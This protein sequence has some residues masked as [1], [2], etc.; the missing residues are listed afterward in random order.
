[1]G[2]H[3]SVSRWTG[4]VVGSG[5]CLTLW[6]QRERLPR[7]GVARRKRTSDVHGLTWEAYVSC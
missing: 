1:V 4:D 3:G 5:I 7:T 2:T 6:S